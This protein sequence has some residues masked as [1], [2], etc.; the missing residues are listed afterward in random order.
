MN[1]HEYQIVQPVGKLYI[2]KLKYFLLVAKP[3]PPETAWEKEKNAVRFKVVPVIWDQFNVDTVL[4]NDDATS[5]LLHD[6]PHHIVTT[7]E[8]VIEFCENLPE[9]YCRLSEYD[10]STHR[11]SCNPPEM[12]SMIIKDGK[13]VPLLTINQL[14]EA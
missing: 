8:F 10:V 3:L 7:A 12:P 11:L 9:I 6:V 2:Q 13:E 4:L 5:V 1:N 14:T